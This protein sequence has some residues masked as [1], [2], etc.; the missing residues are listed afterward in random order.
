MIP[1]HEIEDPRAL[2]ERFREAERRGNFEESLEVCQALLEA[3]A[4]EV[5]WEYGTKIL[6]S[7]ENSLTGQRTANIFKLLFP[8]CRDPDPCPI[9]LGSGRSSEVCVVC[10]VVGCEP[11]RPCEGS[12]VNRENGPYLLKKDVRRVYYKSLSNGN[13]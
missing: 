2:E 5:V 13:C 10:G 1:E 9:C 8:Y 7:S 12:G 3:G 4:W 6:E 11:C